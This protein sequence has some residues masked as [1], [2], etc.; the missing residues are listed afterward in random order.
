M[1][2]NRP[3]IALLAILIGSIV[4]GFGLATGPTQTALAGAQR[5]A[6]AGTGTDTVTR[7]IPVGNVTHL[8]RPIPA[9]P[10]AGLHWV[11]TWGAAAAP[12][13]SANPRSLSGFSHETLREPVFTTSAGIKLRVHFTN[14][15]G[16]RPLWIGHASIGVDAGHAAIAPHTLHALRFH[17]RDFVRI[18]PGGATW[19]DPLK[20]TVHALEK[21][22]VSI[23]VARPSGPATMHDQARETSYLARGRHV[24]DARGRDYRTGF[25]TWYFMDRIQLLSGRHTLGALVALGDSITAGVGSRQN[26]W[27]SWPYELAR[28]LSALA[29]T[30]GTGS[31]ISVIDEGIGGNRLLNDSACCGLSALHRFG[32][33]VRQIPGAREVI[34]LEGVNDLGFAHQTNALTAPHTAVTAAEIIDGYKQAIADAHAAHLQIWG[35][36]LTPYRGSRYWTAADETIREQVNQWILHSGAF[37]GVINLAKVLADPFDPERLNPAYNSGDHLHPNSAG[38][39]AMAQAIRLGA[40]LH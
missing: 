14:V 36:T 19:S 1:L 39:R 25:S 24:F 28:R 12:P 30:K 18:P 2:I 37:D 23:Y 16:K 29:G 13:T 15:Y 10:A 7:S 4:A 40:L 38:Y 6:P 34:L 32:A 11:A 8:R 5:I 26:G 27:A 17:G 31:T 22:T 35:V 20:I 9:R 33:D 3:S 21:L